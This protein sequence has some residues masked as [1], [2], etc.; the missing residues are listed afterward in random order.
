MGFEFK[1]KAPDEQESRWRIDE[2]FINRVLS[3][4]TDIRPSGDAAIR[5]VR[6]LVDVAIERYRREVK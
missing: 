6:G 5:H 3:E 4:L 2:E 1:P